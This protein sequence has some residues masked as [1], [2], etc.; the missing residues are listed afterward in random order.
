L[1]PNLKAFLKKHA[2]CYPRAIEGI[3][4]RVIELLQTLEFEGNVRELENIARKILFQKTVGDMI[5][6]A[7]LPPEILQYAILNHTV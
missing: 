2:A 4:P 5:E 7:D 1:T 6:I 3:H